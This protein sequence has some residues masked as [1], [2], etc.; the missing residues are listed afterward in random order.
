MIII[1]GKV[2]KVMPTGECLILVPN[3]TSFSDTL[4][5]VSD[6]LRVGQQVEIVI[7]PLK[8]RSAGAGVASLTPSVAT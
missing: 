4:Q 1:Y 5:V 6:K 3:S 8:V 2:S 7:T